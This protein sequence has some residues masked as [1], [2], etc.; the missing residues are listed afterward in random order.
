MRSAQAT[1]AR[2]AVLQRSVA[3]RRI[4]QDMI[5]LAEMYQD[6]GTMVEQQTYPVQEIQEKAEMTAN[7][8][9]DAN[10]QMSRAII[11]LR[12][13]NKWKW[14]ILLVCGKNDLKPQ[15]CTYPT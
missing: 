14:W 8:T 10:E 5:A 11:S 1:E 12:N 13:A 2:N 3:I 4:E 9:K 15:H 6:V 7:Y